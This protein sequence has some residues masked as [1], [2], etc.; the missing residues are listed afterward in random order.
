[1]T[2][3]PAKGLKGIDVIVNR[4]SMICGGI[5]SYLVFNF[6]FVFDKFSSFR[7]LLL[8]FNHAVH[9]VLSCELVSRDAIAIVALETKQS[10]IMRKYLNG[11]VHL[12]QT[13][14]TYS[15]N[16]CVKIYCLHFLFLNILLTSFTLTWATL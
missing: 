6:M 10:K 11:N 12:F 4:R 14:T 7:T 15:Q 9:A 13:S 3:E 2:K 16:L 1:M 8:T 5:V